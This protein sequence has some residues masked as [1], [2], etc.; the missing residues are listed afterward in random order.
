M[1]SRK[2]DESLQRS[3]SPFQT[4]W[5]RSFILRERPS[6]LII[7]QLHCITKLGAE[8]L[9]YVFFRAT[10]YENAKEA[11]Q[12]L[13]DVRMRKRNYHRLCLFG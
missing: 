6:M 5:V 9:F 7:S 13:A 8:A 2:A 1:G 11:L 10:D 4:F 3:A 12:F